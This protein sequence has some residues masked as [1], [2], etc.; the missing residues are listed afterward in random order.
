MVR[1]F[2]RYSGY[3]QLGYENISSAFLALAVGVLASIG[4]AVCEKN[5]PILQVMRKAKPISTKD[6]NFL[7]I[8]I[9]IETE[10]EIISGE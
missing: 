3:R 4:M 6:Q 10:S 9:C 8:S 7:F 2:G 5:I 1:I